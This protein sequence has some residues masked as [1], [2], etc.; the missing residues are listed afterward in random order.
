[1]KTHRSLARLP[2]LAATLLLGA[3]AVSAIVPAARAR[4]GYQ[5]AVLNANPAAYWRFESVNDTSLVNG[6]TN[7][8]QGN[9]TVSAPGGGAPLAG[10]PGNR[11]LVLDGSGDF[12]RTGLSTQYTF[13]NAVTY[14]T[15]INLS[16]LPST[17]GR[18][19]S[20][21][22]KSQ[23]GND[24]DFQI[25]TDNRLYLYADG[26]SN[27][28]AAFPGGLQLD[29]WQM[30]AATFDDNAGFQ[31]LYLNGN[32]LAEQL[33]APNHGPG[34]SELSI[35]ENLLFT[36]RFLQGRMDEVAVFDRALS[37]AEISGLYNASFTVP[38]PSTYALALGGLGLLLLARRAHRRRARLA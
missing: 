15:W 29:T 8:Y 10:D 28:N 38:E 22:A 12:V 36:N 23:N 26:G 14:V 34:N 6:F 30:L 25:Q 5:Q 3:V 1:M 17:A 9:A 13:A 33:S 21:L 2:V 19:F 4:S 24:L 16:A 27:T 37:T 31:R 18:T 7:S 35:G 32:L 20:L 11:A